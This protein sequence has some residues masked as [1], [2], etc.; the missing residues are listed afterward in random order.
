MEHIYKGRRVLGMVKSEP[1]DFVVEEIT[2]GG[3]T[4]EIS[5]T[6][7]P[8]MLGVATSGEASRF[9]MFVLQKRDWNTAQALHAVAKRVGRGIRSTAFAGTKDRNA[10]TTQLCSIF[11][12]QPGAVMSVR[13]KDLSI[14]GAWA[15]DAAVEMGSL[16][17]N[18]F[19]VRV[20]GATGAD[21]LDDALSVLNGRFPNYF[22]PQRFGVRGNNAEIGT[23]ML[24]QDFEGAVRAYLT[25]TDNETNADAVGARKRLAEEW[26]FAAALRY[27]P[28]YLKYE[29]QVMEY[30][31]R[32]PG[33]Y[34]NALRKLPR[35]I[36]LMFV[37]AV[38]AE[39]FNTELEQRIRAG[40]AAPV[41]GDLVC[42][43][44]ALGFPDYGNARRYAHGDASD[45]FVIGTVVGYDTAPNQLERELMEGMGLTIDMFKVKGMP[46]LNARG[47]QRVMFAPY[48]GMEHSEGQ[49]SLS[50]RFSL[51][52]G[53]YAT[54]FLSE[55]VEEKAPGHAEE[56]S[57]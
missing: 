52:S 12:A 55:V 24:K 20:K 14:N 28:R 46:E 19:T 1:E 29:L 7:T 41:A 2:T 10:V 9:T 30:L 35:S 6:Y 43:A 5:R 32:F 56:S 33:N 11:G 16:S 42:G 3:I 54:S 45:G 31:S 47:A 13:V 4:L 26:D 37:H 25:S 34:A 48:V 39:I 36:V 15:S 18:R 50:M 44:G 53:S 23:L 51:P 22:G 40:S 38:E 8:E 21:S 27:F 57:G 49:D 17:G